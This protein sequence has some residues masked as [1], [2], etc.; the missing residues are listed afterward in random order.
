MIITSA[1]AQHSLFLGPDWQFHNHHHYL[2]S[3]FDISRT[4]VGQQRGFAHWGSILIGF[5]L[6]LTE[7]LV[8]C[9]CLLFTQRKSGKF[10]H[11]GALRKKGQG[12]IW[13]PETQRAAAPAPVSGEPNREL[14]RSRKLTWYPEWTLQIRKIAQAAMPRPQQQAQ[15]KTLT[16]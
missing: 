2:F 16:I 12:Q 6:P 13:M 10:W 9:F 1:G 3:L 11:N 4:I 8:R 15:W 5:F 7:G 14:E